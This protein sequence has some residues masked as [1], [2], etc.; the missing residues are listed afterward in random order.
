M[1]AAWGPL[2]PVSRNALQARISRLRRTLG[3]DDGR[4]SHTAGSYRLHVGLG[5]CDDDRLGTAVE[6]ARVDFDAGNANGAA[7]LLRHVLG[8]VRGDPYPSCGR[9]DQVVAA[10]AARLQELIWSARELQAHAT[11]AAGDADRAATLAAALLAQHPLRQQALI[12]RMQ[13]LDALGRR[14]EALAAYT[15]GTRRLADA[16]GLEP[17]P[18]LR[19]AH[20]DILASER[21]RTRTSAAGPGVLTPAGMIEWLAEAGHRDAALA[22][23]TRCAWGWWLTDQRHQGRELLASLLRAAPGHSPSDSVALAA[24]L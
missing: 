17:S 6:K 13:A 12:T 10:A 24:R 16:T 22:L 8:L 9:G 14:A 23:A 19:V 15:E 20:T 3:R 2:A 1:K 18:Q 11:L 4:L 21:V 7:S 5:E